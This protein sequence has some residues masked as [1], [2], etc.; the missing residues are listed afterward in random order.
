MKTYSQKSTDVE[1][2]WYVLDAKG[3]S[4]GRVATNAAT[5]LIGKGKPTVTPHTDGG[6]FVIIINCAEAKVTG[7]KESK[8]MYHQHSGYPGGLTSRTMLEQQEKDPTS[9]I[10]KAVRGM[11]PNNKLREARLARL[12]IYEGEDHNH[13]PQKPTKYELK[14]KI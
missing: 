4:F 5:L 9:I 14:G 1:R 11:L 12:K 10:Y 7:G 2:K 13:N 3:V 8:K 6:D